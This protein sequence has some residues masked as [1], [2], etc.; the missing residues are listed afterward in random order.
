[1][2]FIYFGS[3]KFA[4]IVLEN[5]C[6]KDV[7][8]ALIITSPDKPKGRGLK[9]AATEVSLFAREK[10]I[11][12]FQPGSLN[13]SRVTRELDVYAADFFIVADYG[14]IVPLPLIS[15]PG[16]MFLG[17]H[18]S[19]LPFY[20]GAAP[21]SRAIIQGEKK[22]GLT[23]F[24]IN[25]KVDAGEIIRQKEINI[26]EDDDVFS[27]TVSLGQL[28]AAAVVEAAEN[29][30]SGEYNLL[31]QD[32]RRCSFAPKFKKEEGRI[33]WNLSARALRDL[34]RAILDWPGAYTYYKGKTIKILEARVI[35]ADTRGAAPGS[36]IK[37]DKEG[38]YAAAGTDILKITKVKPQDKKEMPAH[39]FACGARVWAGDRFEEHEKKIRS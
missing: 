7:V 32:E 3:G 23:I 19:L 16:K 15:L 34:I 38:I 10:K 28:G 37:I 18:P 36:I 26:A 5:L 13:D 24:K 4:R 20:R 9:L 31:R 25:D 35:A 21:I 2:K 12:F 8:P 39:A 30:L 33:N 11:P 1:M 27:L 6:G 17:V 22:T 29:I 14:K